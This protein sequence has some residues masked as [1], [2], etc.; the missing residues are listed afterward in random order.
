MAKLMTK[1][2]E[3]AGAENVVCI[4]TDSAAVNSSAARIVQEKHPGIFWVRCMAHAL[5]LLMEAVGKLDWVK[6][7]TDKGR[8]IVKFVTRHS[9]ALGIYRR[10]QAKT[11][12]KELIKHGVSWQFVRKLD[13]WAIC[14]EQM[15]NT[16]KHGYIAMPCASCARI[17]EQGKHG[18]L[19]TS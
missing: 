9:A 17:A 19:P 6:E 2:I 15:P 4:V 5:D 10:L 13:V 7:V 8:A 16:K 12:A 1:A 14:I 18:L 11:R 3:H